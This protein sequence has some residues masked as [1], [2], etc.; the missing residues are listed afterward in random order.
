MALTTQIKTALGIEEALDRSGGSFMTKYSLM[1]DRLLNVEYEHWA[2]GFPGGNNHGRGH[3]TRVLE[4][5]DHLLG[6]DPLS[7]LDIYEL[8]LTMMAVLYHDIGILRKRT[9]HAEISKAL[10]EGDKSDAYIINSIDKKIIS[11]A[12]VSHSSN[13]DISVTCN[14]FSPEEIIGSHKARPR[15]VAALVR[16]ADELDE[17]YRRADPILMQRVNPPLDS[18]FFW[19]F[20][21][22]VRGVRPKFLAKQIDFN[23]A[24]EGEDTLNIGPVPKGRQRLFLAFC[25]EKFEKINKERVTV[26]RYLPPELQ[27]GGLH[28][29]VKS[30]KK[31]RTWRD[32]RTF[33]FNDR[34]TALMFIQLSR[35][36]L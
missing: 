27:Y 25:A 4:N 21:Q 11:A 30:L 8:F 28:I 22:R 31:H 13:K 34:T 5:L 36:A 12:V 32:P 18:R 16:L 3:I 29:D 24:P 9:N 15:V 17:D 10:L 23:F 19:Q 14:G 35:I 20:C 7:R 33:V 26:N 2:A 1:K 6:P